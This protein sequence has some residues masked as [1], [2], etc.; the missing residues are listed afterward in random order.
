MA[1]LT[2]ISITD[3]KTGRIGKVSPENLL[4]VLNGGY[5]LHNA[6]ERVAIKD[7]DTGRTGACADVR[8]GSPAHMAP[9][10]IDGAKVDVRA[11]V[12]ALG[13]VLYWLATGRLP[14]EGANAPQVLRRVLED[15]YE[16]N[17]VNV[18]LM[19]SFYDLPLF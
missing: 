16:E 15:D 9:E 3:P 5:E 7:P 11:D 12:F 13:T 2:K 17:R 14:F 19:Y 1:G 18:C 6:P 10:L 8:L 4:T